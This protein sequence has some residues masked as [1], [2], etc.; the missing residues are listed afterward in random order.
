MNKLIF[1]SILTLASS[2]CFGQADTQCF[3]LSK[4]LKSF[5]LS[6]PDLLKAPGDQAAYKKY[7]P[8]NQLT[9]SPAASQ[10]CIKQ[11]GSLN[12]LTFKDSTGRNLLSFDGVP[13]QDQDPRSFGFVIQGMKGIAFDYQGSFLETSQVFKEWYYGVTTDVTKVSF[14]KVQGEKYSMTLVP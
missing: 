9:L 1:I 13:F 7:F 4:P 3:K 12:F 11:G 8:G 5:K 2:F 10:F 6:G 14:K